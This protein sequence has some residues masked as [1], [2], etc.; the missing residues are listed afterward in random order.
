MGCK[1]RAMVL[2][3]VDFP[4]P[5]APTRTVIFSVGTEK[6]NTINN[7][8][9]CDTRQKH[10]RG[11]APALLRYVPRVRQLNQRQTKIKLILL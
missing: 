7:D 2:S 10:C 3:N 1:I 9:S 5:F 11:S 4:Q 8:F 6:E